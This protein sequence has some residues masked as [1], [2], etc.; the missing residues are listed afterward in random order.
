MFPG[1][2]SMRPPHHAGEMY[3]SDD[4]CFVEYSS[5]Q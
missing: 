1:N 3:Y 2:A 4:L 5:L